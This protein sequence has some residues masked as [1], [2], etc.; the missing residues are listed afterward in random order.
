MVE[1]L[2]RDQ[3]ADESGRGDLRSGQSPFWNS[4]Q[5]PAKS[6]EADL[7]VVVRTERRKRVDSLL[8]AGRGVSHARKCR[9]R[10]RNQRCRNRSR[11]N[12]EL[13]LTGLHLE[14][15]RHATRYPEAYWRRR[16][17]AIPAIRA[18]TNAMGRWHLR[19]GRIRGGRKLFSQGHRVGYPPEPQS[20]RRRAATINLG[21]AL[22]YLGRDEEAY[23]AFYKATWNQAWHPPA[24]TP[25]PKWI[26]RRATGRR[27]SITSTGRLRV[28][29]D[30]FEGPEPESDRAAK[31]GAHGGGGPLLR[32]TLALDPLDSWAR[33]LSGGQLECDNQA[34]LDIALD[35]A[36][37]G[38]EAE[39]IDILTAANL[40]QPMAPFPWSGTRLAGSACAAG[41][42]IQGRRMLCAGRAEPARLLLSQPAGGD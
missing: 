13:Y 34:R 22:R 5:L 8:A 36:R 38:L 30:N 32:D 3:A 2:H 23:A 35:L 16:Y 24:I 20:L 4:A 37:A 26:A 39:A 27:L 18:A 7:T 41:P 9:R 1:L 14:Q 10:Q 15:Y 17:A 12:D 11:S 42:Q 29:T 28:N 21:L 33:Y 40:G 19:A 25:S 6:Q 31:A